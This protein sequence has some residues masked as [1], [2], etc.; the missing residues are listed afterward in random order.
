MTS[1]KR[2][3]AG[4]WAPI[5]ALL[6]LSLAACGKSAEKTDAATAAPAPAQVVLRPLPETG[7][8]VEWGKVEVPTPMAAGKKAPIQVTLRNAGD[9]VWP[10]RATGDPAQTGANAVRLAWRLLP[11]GPADG[12]GYAQQR[13]DLPQPLAPGQSVTLT[14]EIKA[15]DQPGDHEIQLDLVQELVSWF[16]R[17]GAAK[18]IVKI[19]VT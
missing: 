6:L 12:D 1:P 2:G 16:E 14:V 15:P 17:R 8:K 9:Q 10:N 11:A 19:K 7:Y 4:R 13:V 18:Q 5:A 3:S